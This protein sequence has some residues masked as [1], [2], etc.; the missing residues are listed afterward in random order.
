MT[1]FPFTA[2]D[3]LLFIGTSLQPDR[4]AVRALLPEVADWDAVVRR[5]LATHLAPL[6]YRT[7]K[8]IEAERMVPPR[9]FAA[10]HN[11]YNGV[12][13]ANI[14]MYA[15]LSE[16]IGAWNSE[17][18]PL[19]VLKG[20]F[21]AETVYKDIGLRHISDIDMLVKDVDVERCKQ[22]AMQMGWT[23][24]EMPQHSQYV[25]ENFGSAHPYKFFKGD[26]CIELHVHVH[27]RGRS[28]AVDIS[29][30]WAR[31]TLGPLSGGKVMHLHP[32]DLLQHL[33]IHLY[34]HMAGSELKISA[35]CDIRETIAHYGEAIDWAMLRAE[36]LRYSALE[37]VQCV[38]HICREFWGVEVP[39]ALLHGLSESQAE[40][41]TALFLDYF[42]YGNPG[43]PEVMARSM[44]TILDML[45]N[46]NGAGDKGRFLLHYFFPSRKYLKQ[47]YRVRGPIALMLHVYHPLVQCTK[48]VKVIYRKLVGSK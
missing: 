26:T 27:N 17:G 40:A 15:H 21:L 38:L 29:D 32:S 2:E 43:G 7:I 44:D 3:R 14:R 47:R 5:G 8:V 9:A 35:F 16:V 42:Q 28:Y 33:C 39:D 48:V 12:L 37:E 34:K 46:L 10:L 20:M 36:S 13:A 41:N 4:E 1:H 25:A 22:L 30:Y 18:I 45:G 6:L 23:V 31:A 19:I 11:S 24:K